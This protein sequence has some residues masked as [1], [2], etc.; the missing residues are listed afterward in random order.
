[1]V[2]NTHPSDEA[3]VRD[4]GDWTVYEQLRRGK[5]NLLSMTPF[6]LDVDDLPPAVELDTADLRAL[7][8][9]Y[10][11]DEGWPEDVDPTNYDLQGGTSAIYGQGS[12]TAGP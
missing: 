11:R 5:W 1:M 6:D 4:L 7:R 9:A 2:R 3:S 12:G 10:V 8:K